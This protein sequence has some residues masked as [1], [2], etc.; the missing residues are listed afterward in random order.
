MF[1]ALILSD[2]SLKKQTT[3]KILYAVLFWNWVKESNIR[4]DKLSKNRKIWRI[5]P[6]EGQPFLVTRRLGLASAPSA[7]QRVHSNP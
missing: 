2:A 4:E 5:L 6:K 3:F 7:T 1:L